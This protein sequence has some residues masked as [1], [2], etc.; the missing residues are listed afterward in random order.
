MVIQLQN[1]AATFWGVLCV[2]GNPQHDH[3]SKASNKH[4]VCIPH[5][6]IVIAYCQILPNKNLLVL[7][8]IVLLLVLLLKCYFARVL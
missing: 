2:H 7:D 5:T 8:C 3:I 4:P 1:M 6:Q